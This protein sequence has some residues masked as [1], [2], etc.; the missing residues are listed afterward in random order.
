MYAALSVLAARNEPETRAM[1]TL[2]ADCTLLSFPVAAGS[3]RSVHRKESVWYD[4]LHPD[5]AAEAP[6][7]RGWDLESVPCAGHLQGSS[8]FGHGERSCVW[9][10]LRWFKMCLS[11]Q[12]NSTPLLPLYKTFKFTFIGQGNSRA[13]V[14]P[15]GDDPAQHSPSQPHGSPAWGALCVGMWPSGWHS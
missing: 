8:C 15:F 9:W 3:V 4:V 5:G 11:Y 1:F 6:S 12:Y 14:S 10:N 2:S 7:T 13:R